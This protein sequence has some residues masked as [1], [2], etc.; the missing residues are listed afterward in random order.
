MGFPRGSVIKN[1]PVDTG[2]VGST[3]GSGRPL[4]VGD[5]THCSNFYYKIRW[6]EEPVG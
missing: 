4:G 5:A 3:P 2:D 1:L 6:T